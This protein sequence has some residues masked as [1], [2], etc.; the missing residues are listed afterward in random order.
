M[1]IIYGLLLIGVLFL[2]SFISYKIGKRPKKLTPIEN[3]E[4]LK[5]ERLEKNMQEVMTYSVDKALGRK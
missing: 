5:R 4:Q 2:C 1:N 3:D